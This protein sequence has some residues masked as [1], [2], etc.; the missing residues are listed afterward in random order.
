M[1][2][3]SAVSVRHHDPRDERRRDDVKI[4][5]AMAAGWSF[6]VTAYYAN[7]DNSTAP[8]LIWMVSTAGMVGL[9]WFFLRDDK[10]VDIRG[11]SS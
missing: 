8:Y 9:Y 10:D 1:F 6:I 11:A 4:G 2:L 7:R 5:L 3:P